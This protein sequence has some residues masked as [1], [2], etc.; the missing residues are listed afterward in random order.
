MIPILSLDNAEDRETV[1]S[2]LGRLRLA[3]ADIALGQGK[4]VIAVNEILAD[5]AKRGDEAI[6]DSSRKFDDPAFTAEQIRVTP[7]EMSEAAMRISLQQLAAIRHAIAQVRD[8]QQAMMPLDPRP[9]KRPGVSL[10][11]RFTPVDSAGLYFPGGKASY[12]SS[13]IHLAVPAQVA[14]VQRIAVVTPPSKYGRSDLVLAAAHELKLTHV[15]RAGGAAAIAALAFGTKTIAPVDKIVGPG[16]TYV[17][18]AKRALA[19]CVGIDG[20]LGPSEI[21]VLADDSAN[22]AYIAADLIAQAEHDPGSC[23]LLTTSETLA[24]SV[25]AEI[26]RQ[27]G[28]L[29]RLAA[30]QKALRDWS[31]IIIDASMDNL[32]A[33]ANRFAA[34][35][36][37]VQTRD[38]D[39]VLKKLTHAGAIFLGPWS[40]VAAGDYVAGPSHCLPTNTTARFTSGVSVYEFMKRSSVARY[41][42]A[43]LQ[44]DA[45][46]IT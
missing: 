11:M 23:F 13:L 24:G 20:F 38:D 37:N 15:Y 5:V 39:A 35:H 26:E 28:S 8:Y 19:G 27:G 1:E 25:V 2:L 6:V 4:E 18:L 12:P 14:G 17:Q 7:Q 16:N 30:L 29:S 10:G 3:P 44:F 40:P 43:G 33:L 41:D 9:L 34:E 32:I 36:V 31:A 22:P 21:L 42:A 45:E 46:A